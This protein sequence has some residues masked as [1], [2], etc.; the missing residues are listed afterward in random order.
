MS[1]GSLTS[2]LVSLQQYQPPSVPSMTLMPTCL[3][4]ALMTLSDL[5]EVP[6]MQAAHLS[7]MTTISSATVQR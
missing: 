3:P 7:S 4:E 1:Q 5:T 6:H 2:N